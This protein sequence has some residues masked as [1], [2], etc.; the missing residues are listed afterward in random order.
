[1]DVS[2]TTGNPDVS[3]P[4]CTS[5]LHSHEPCPRPH[6]PKHD[7]DAIA[8]HREVLDRNF[9]CDGFNR[10]EGVCLCVREGRNLTP[11]LITRMTKHDWGKE[12][13]KA[14]RANITT[15]ELE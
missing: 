14:S 7:R 13:R 4:I 11:G 5:L 6:L 8:L 10:G 1:M 9:F 2:S 3:A 15:V 12:R